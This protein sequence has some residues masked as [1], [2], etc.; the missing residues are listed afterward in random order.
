MCPGLAFKRKL[1]QRLCLYQLEPKTLPRTLMKPELNSELVVEALAVVLTL[2]FEEAEPVWLVPTSPPVRL[3][4]ISVVTVE[5]SP[6]NTLLLLAMP[7]TMALAPPAES[8]EKVPATTP[9]AAEA[10]APDAV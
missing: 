4:V 9:I 7:E 5:P 2:L 3:L 1:I 8:L 10:V 6:K